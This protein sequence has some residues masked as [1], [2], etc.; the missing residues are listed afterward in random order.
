[1][2]RWH[3]SVTMKSKVSMGMRGCRRP[4]SARVIDG[5]HVEQRLLLVLR[6]ELRLAAQHRV[7]P[8]DG[9]DAHLADRVERVARSGA[10]RCRAR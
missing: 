6:V 1:M 3:S 8:L 9:G 4:P 5:A 2:E 10:G 7:E